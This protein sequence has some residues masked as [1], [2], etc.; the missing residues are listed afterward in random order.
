M[1]LLGET[2]GNVCLIFIIL[3]PRHHFPALIL[4]CYLF[5]VINLSGEYDC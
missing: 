2:S 5:V 1:I 3:R 4:F